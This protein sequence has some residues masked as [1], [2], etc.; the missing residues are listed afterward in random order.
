MPEDEVVVARIVGDEL[1]VER[2]EFRQRSVSVINCSEGDFEKHVQRLRPQLVVW[3]APD[4]RGRRLAKALEEGDAE[5]E[6]RPG[7]MELPGWTDLPLSELLRAASQPGR[8]QSE[9]LKEPPFDV[10]A[11][12][13][14]AEPPKSTPKAPPKVPAVEDASN[15]LGERLELL[16]AVRA[17]RRAAPGSEGERAER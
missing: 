15:H 10:E 12:L 6:W 9:P 11:E 14:A 2:Y 3:A 5:T 7:S 1:R 16:L 4:P 8:E 13:G 17:A